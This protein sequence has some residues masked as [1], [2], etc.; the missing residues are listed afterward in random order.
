MMLKVAPLMLLLLAAGGALGDR[1]LSQYTPG[2][3]IHNTYPG[4]MPLGSHSSGRRSPQ[5]HRFRRSPEEN[6]RETRPAPKPANRPF[7]SPVPP[8]GKE[9]VQTLPALLPGHTSVQTLPAKLP[10]RREGELPPPANLARPFER[11]PHTGP[12]VSPVPPKG[13]VPVQ[14]L[15]EELPSTRTGELP[16][17]KESLTRPIDRP[18]HDGLLISPVPPKGH[19][20][21]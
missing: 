7:I 17:N 14:T 13:N 2:R 12:Q 19:V 8:P 20:P 4:I 10:E 15:P 11:P 21:I 18:P 5:G 16:P 9:P 1:D 3:P 6:H